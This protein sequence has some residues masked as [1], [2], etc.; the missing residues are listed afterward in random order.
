MSATYEQKFYDNLIEEFNK[1]IKRV[2][3][4]ES[5]KTPL[6]TNSETLLS[7]KTT[8]TSTY[9]ALISYIATH[10]EKFNAESKAILSNRIDYS[11]QKLIECF[12]VLRLNYDWSDNQFDLID[13]EKVGPID[14]DFDE[15]SA[16]EELTSDDKL[17]TT[18]S[19][20]VD[21]AN[22]SDISIL[23]QT[24][25]TN[26]NSEAN[27]IMPQTTSEFLRLAASMI[28]YKYDG[29]PLKLES[30]VADV[31]LVSEVAS[32]EN[33]DLCLKFVKAK[34]EGKALESIPED[35]ASVTAIINALKNE[36]K[37]EN[38]KIIEGKMSALRIEKGNFT[39]FSEQAEKLAEALRRTL[40]VEG[41]SRAKAQELTVTKTVE[42]CRK[43][44]RN[45]IVKSVLASKAFDSPKDVIAK[46]ITENTIARTE[47]REALNFKN[48][49]FPQNGNGNNNRQQKKFDPQ[50][51]RNGSNRFNSNQSNRQHNNGSNGNSS[52]SDGQNSGHNTRRFYNSNR[53]N[54][55]FGNRQNR[56]NGNGGNEHTIRIVSG[57][58]DS[59]STD[60]Q[61]NMYHVPMN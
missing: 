56:N 59:P 55:N 22:K 36:I 34:L 20:V 17:N 24:K 38:S 37:P 40:V 48:K 23:V 53:Q 44:A 60:G 45:E 52:R 41:I 2:K 42:V 25:S 33:A 26:S 49:K 46:F 31:E 13:I 30:F 18:D 14:D 27:G 3:R 9:N 5:G 35:V 61:G 51:N 32:D 57:N 11:K 50:R 28:N 58:Q 43:M 15:S 1:A 16:G 21:E 39:K 19:L 6:T 12:K 29:D 4:Y 47:F 10:F 8:I 54:N 7:Y